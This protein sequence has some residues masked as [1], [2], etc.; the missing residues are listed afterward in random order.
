MRATLLFGVVILIV[1]VSCSSPIDEP[2]YH[3][4]T[5]TAT[6][7]E[8]GAVSPSQ[9]HFEEGTEVELS[10]TANEHWLFDRWEGDL[11]GVNNPAMIIMNSDKDIAAVFTERTYELS[12]VIEGEG[13]VHERLVQE[14]SADYL[15]GT[16]VELEAEPAENW[17]FSHWEG[18]VEGDENPVQITIYET[19]EVK[20][21]F[22]TNIYQL[23]VHVEGEGTVEQEVVQARSTDYP[24]G[25]IVELTAVPDDGW[26]FIR[27]EG[28]LAGDDNPATLT[29]DEAKSV[30]AIFTEI[31]EEEYSLTIQI[32]G[33]GSVSEAVV[34]ARSTDYPEGTIVELTAVPEEGWE[35]IRWEGDLS[36]D[37][38]PSQL[39]IDE[40]KTVTAVFTEIPEE[41][42]SLTIQIEGE[43]SVSEAIVQARSTDYLAGTIVEL[44]AVPDDGW[45]FIR[46]EGDLTGDEN[47]AT[48]TIDEAKSVTA[49][50]TEIP[51]E[52]YS[53]TIQ[54]EGEGSVS[55]AVVQARSTD[56]PAGT[57][58]ELTA[59]PG[60]G[61]EFSH[62]EGDL[63]GDEN[64]AQLTMDAERE[65]TAVFEEREYPLIIHIEG[66]GSVSEEIVQARTTEH[67]HGTVVEL[68][69]SPAPG[70]EFIRW[71]GDLD[72]DEN[73]ATL[74]IDEAK[75][76]TAI[77]TEIPE[78]EYSLTIQ[79]EGEG[80]VSE[81][82]VQAR[83]T[84]Y[85]EGTIVELTAVPEEGWEFIRW[86]GDLSGD[87]NPS[88][89]TMDSAKEVTAVFEEIEY[90][91]TIQIEGEGSV[92]EAIVQARTTDYTSGTIVE[93]T[94]VPEDGWE[95]I[96][97]EG[98]LD[99]DENPSQ[100]TMDSAK[101]VT[102]VFEEIEYTLTIQIEGEGSVD[103]AIV[104]ARTTDY[105]SGTIVELT[106][107]PED[108]WEFIRWEGDLDGDENPSQLTMDSGK[109]VTAVFEEIE[110]TLTIQIE[111]EG[112]VDEAIVQA[113]TTDYTS[114]TI[115]ELTAVPEDG[116]EFIRWEGDLDG[117]ENPSQ[118][119]M[120][121]AK[122]VTAVFEEI[123]YTL[124]IQIEGEGSVDEAIV[125]ARTTD[126]TSG[127]IVELTAVPEDGWEFIRWEGD[128]DGDENPSQLTMDSSKEV[129]AVF[130]EIE[131]TLTIQIEG[132]GSVDEAIVQART[133][134]YTSGTIVELTAVPEDG[135]EFI[136]WEGDL[137][138]DE[139]PSQLTMDSSK[140]VTAVFEEIPPNRRR[141]PPIRL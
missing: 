123:E 89:L 78:E 31:P 126:Y 75:S 12:I 83:S 140:E 29:I 132:E 37:E 15:Q 92:D 23:T 30:T 137:D 91:L 14:R 120:D 67:P 99:G 90:T 2:K 46:W 108:G 54:I 134:D 60:E 80:S 34:Q 136:R 26:E 66:E 76:V 94:A 95:F 114:G 39:T 1:M 45:E 113:R 106:A 57:I 21:V 128:L 72:G 100:L 133:T 22:T 62:W 93:L 36:G 51:E 25:T 53:L 88:Q 77:F 16:V 81:A 40:A 87:E 69:A 138:G 63:T 112:S 42:Y 107:V 9:G 20:A 84:D 111:G 32:E 116:W 28:D 52:E 55:E 109:E 122:E 85:P 47:P 56:Y 65:V 96:R 3:S 44:T 61:W 97:W 139:N 17:E 48:L 41:E 4:L 131:Y 6:P 70:W 19:A 117:D 103:E 115:V 35:F 8:G 104:Q 5:A 119:T 33:E 121:S 98:D 7:E 125:Q 64:P 135:W 82:V 24:E 130:E 127:T 11:S 27:W 49:V 59:V 118:L 18:D 102:A 79:I 50:F 74:T 43:G 86:E 141:G 13:Q 71:E 105:T 38:N 73:P 68:T 101:E 58:V 10:A 110:Y 124:T 129:T